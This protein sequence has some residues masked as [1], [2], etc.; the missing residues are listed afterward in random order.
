MESSLM[1]MMMSMQ[2]CSEASIKLYEVLK[3]DQRLSSLVSF[4]P[5]SGSHC[6][7]IKF[8][9]PIGKVH[10]ISISYPSDVYGNKSGN[11]NTIE[12]ALIDISDKL[13]YIDELGYYDVCR[14]D[15]ASE[16]VDEIV[17]I[18]SSDCE[19]THC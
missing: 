16:V 2:R 19:N 15:S 12:T 13:C 17:R 14:F 18:S 3:T 10:G 9:N 7:R 5:H 8:F 11:P 4:E 6:F 1:Q